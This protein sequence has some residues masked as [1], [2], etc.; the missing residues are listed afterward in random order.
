MICLHGSSHKP[1]IAVCGC[2]FTPSVWVSLTVWKKKKDF[3][4]PTNR[5]ISCNKCKVTSMLPGRLSWTKQVLPDN[6]RTKT[7]I[8][9]GACMYVQLCLSKMLVFNKFRSRHLLLFQSCKLSSNPV[10]AKRR[11]NLNVRSR[12]CKILRGISA[13]LSNNESDHP[14]EFKF[15]YALGG[16]I[17]NTRM[18][19]HF[20]AEMYLWWQR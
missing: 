13:I 19:I 15:S 9:I 20:R 2:A 10:S 7:N 12:V 16:Q 8:H 5:K 4:C 6:P 17:L 3:F 14:S 18:Q 1:Y 11:R